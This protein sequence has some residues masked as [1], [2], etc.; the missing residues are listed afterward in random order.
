MSSGR[1]P[2]TTMSTKEDRWT[3]VLTRMST[4]SKAQ[5]TLAVDNNV[6]KAR[7]VD[8]GH[9]RGSRQLKAQKM[10]AGKWKT[11]KRTLT[12]GSPANESWQ[13]Y[14]LWSGEEHRRGTSEECE[15][16]CEQEEVTASERNAAGEE[17]REEFCV[18]YKRRVLCCT[19]EV[20]PV[21]FAKNVRPVFFAKFCTRERGVFLCTRSTYS[22]IWNISGPTRSFFV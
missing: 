3:P 20:R 13:L 2:S 8:A 1:W 14:L 4:K 9:R 7:P 5:R 15:R 17:H 21:F 18:L 10:D 22:N 12:S 16:N 11:S 6:H 19:V